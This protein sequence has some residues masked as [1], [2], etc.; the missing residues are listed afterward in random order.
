MLTC[1]RNADMREKLLVRAKDCSAQ[2]GYVNSGYVNSG[3]V[4]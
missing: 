4:N 1:E 3:Y 2:P